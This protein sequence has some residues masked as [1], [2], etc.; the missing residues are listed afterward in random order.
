MSV[1]LG[2]EYRDSVTGFTAVATA[3]TETLHGPVS[4]CLERADDDGKPEEVWLP[5]ARLVEVEPPPRKVGFNGGNESVRGWHCGNVGCEV[6]GPHEHA[7]GSDL[8]PPEPVED[9]Q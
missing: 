4:V 8:P 3:R 1:H 6:I 7:S 9:Q 5:E 2:H